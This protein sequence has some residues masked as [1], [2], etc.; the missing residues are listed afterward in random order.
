MAATT[1]FPTLSQLR[2]SDYSYF[3]QLAGYLQRISPKV[4]GAVDQ[5]AKDVQHPGGGEW[6]GRDRKSVV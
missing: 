5:L 6:E 1:G 4:Q 3:G 2:A